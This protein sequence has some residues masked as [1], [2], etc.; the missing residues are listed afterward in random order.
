M[1][2]GRVIMSEGR[3]ITSE[4]GGAWSLVRWTI[5]IHE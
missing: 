5:V 1:S 4:E 3:A 2:E